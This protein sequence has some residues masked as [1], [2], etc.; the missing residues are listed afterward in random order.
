MVA[1]RW[2]LFI[3]ATAICIAIV[4][5][6]EPPFSFP[7][8]MTWGKARDLTAFGMAA[9]RNK[10]NCQAVTREDNLLGRGHARSAVD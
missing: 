4:V 6:P 5:F 3:N 2:P 10:G 1:R 8:K 9:P 7:T